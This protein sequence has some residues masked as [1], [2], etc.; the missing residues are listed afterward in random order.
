[1]TVTWTQLQWVWPYIWDQCPGHHDTKAC[2]KM[3]CC[4][5]PPPCRPCRPTMR[6]SHA[7][8]EM[9]C[10]FRQQGGCVKVKEQG[11]Y[12]APSGTVASIT[13]AC[14]MDAAPSRSSC[15][16]HHSLWHWSSM[17]ERK[18]HT[19]TSPAMSMACDCNLS[20]SPTAAC[21]LLVCRKLSK[22]KA[23]RVTDIVSRA[24]VFREVR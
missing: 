6:S 12:D 19:P 17:L 16:Q 10:A 5:V 9:S 4:H 8:S 1:M 24:R 15:Q 7:S 13:T 2:L 22:H 21:L 20:S 14:S 3:Y 18:A 23:Y 11:F